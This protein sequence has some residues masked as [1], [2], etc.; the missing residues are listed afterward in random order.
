MENLA[1]LAPVMGALGDGDQG[2]ALDP[3]LLQR[4]AHARHLA[5]AAID[6]HEIGPDRLVTALLPLIALGMFGQ[7]AE[8][9]PH[10][11]THHPEIV[12]PLR[13]LDVELA[14]LTFLEALG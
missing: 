10:H 11:F 9:A 1:P 14:I 3:H 7:I 4:I 12:V 8:A 13:A 5:L 2:N 6:Q